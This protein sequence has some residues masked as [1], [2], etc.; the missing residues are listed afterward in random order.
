MFYRWFAF[1]LCLVASIYAHASPVNDYAYITDGTNLGIINVNQQMLQGYV[2]PSPNG[3]WAP[4]RIGV[5]PDAKSLFITNSASSNQIGNIGVVNP[6]LQQEVSS[7]L[8]NN[9][10][11][12]TSVTITPDGKY[13]YVSLLTNNVN[14]IAIID[15]NTQKIINYVKNFNGT[16]N[17]STMMVWKIVFS[18]DGKKA[19]IISRFNQFGGFFAAILDV[20][21]NIVV[22]NFD[23]NELYDPSD[24]FISSDSKTAYFAITGSTASLKIVDLNNYQV[25]KKVSFSTGY[26]G[27]VLRMV[28][29]PDLSKIYFATITHLYILNIASSKIVNYPIVTS[30]GSTPL[31]AINSSGTTVYLASYMTSSS[32]NIETVNTQTDQMANFVINGLSSVKDIRLFSM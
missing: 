11:Q 18:P 19:V 5:T 29:T 8:L 16:N 2:K 9:G 28:A 12:P 30:N 23:I 6:I 20:P 14:S 13:A 22:K 26:D 25:V 17:F 24:A 32:C 27:G 15:I 1:I 3:V 21:N 31:L 10:A 7:V 4:N